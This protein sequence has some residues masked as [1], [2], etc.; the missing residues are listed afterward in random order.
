[1]DDDAYWDRMIQQRE[2]EEDERV[3]RDK[4][5]RDELFAEGVRHASDAH[6][7]VREVRFTRG[8]PCACNSGGF[9]GGCGH[10]GCGGRR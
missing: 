2:R 10:A 5:R 6:V 4:M 3:A 1:M 7:S 9:C 8:C